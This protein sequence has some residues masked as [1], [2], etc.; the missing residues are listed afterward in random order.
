[1]KPFCSNDVLKTLYY[2]LFNSHLSYGLSTWGSNVSDTQMHGLQVLQNRILWIIA[3]VSQENPLHCT[4][5]RKSL[6]ILTIK[7]QLKVQ[8]SSI[9]WD[10]DHESLPSHLKS[11]FLRSSDV[12][13]YNTRSASRGNLY[14]TK[15]NS[16]SYGIKSLKI[17]GVKI[18]NDLLGKDI[19]RNAKTK[20]SFIKN[21]KFEL[22]SLY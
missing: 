13:N 7:D 18:L 5:I 3:S 8:I 21:L 16:T 4:N 22:L 9:M 6:G 14:F 2:S 15:T 20:T 17:Q 10:Y 19:Y 1:M 12:H 11:F